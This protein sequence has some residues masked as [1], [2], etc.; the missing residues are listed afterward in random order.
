MLKLYDYF[1]S[2]ACFRV[3]IAFNL[4]ELE[5]EKVPIHLVN[6]GGE[7]LSSYY[8]A[9]NP[10]G[11]VPTIQEDEKYLSQSLA[12][13]EYVNDL[14][15]TPALLSKDPYLTALIRAFA[16]TITA[17]IHPLNNLRVLTFLKNEFEI[18]D[19][20]KTQWYQHW[21]HSGLSALEKQ[22]SL[23]NKSSRFCFGDTPSLADICL[24][25]QMYNAR[26]FNCD[27]STFPLLKKID[28]HC[29]T[30]SAFSEARP[31]PII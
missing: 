21:M 30:H 1:R 4:K 12:I 17:D 27:L 2:S 28:A 22:L 13:I 9:I 24:V 6:N 5:Y 10:L 15:P 23:H 14:Y 7:H 31:E 18:S 11:L 3:R 29:Q 16:L 20:Q 8:K 25:P 26:R 19:E